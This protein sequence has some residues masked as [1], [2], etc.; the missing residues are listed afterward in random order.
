MLHEPRPTFR[1]NAYGRMAT[2]MT[3]CVC[4]EGIGHFS[5][6]VIWVPG[7]YEL[8]ASGRNFIHLLLVER[9]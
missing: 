1:L 4:L 2:M 6:L 9:R 5:R 7:A 8:T 3:L